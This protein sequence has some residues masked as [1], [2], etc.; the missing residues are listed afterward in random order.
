MLNKILCICVDGRNITIYNK[1][2]LDV[3]YKKTKNLQKITLEKPDK[4]NISQIY[5]R[6]KNIYPQKNL[7][8]LN[9]EYTVNVIT[10]KINIKKQK[11]TWDVPTGK[12]IQIIQLFAK[13]NPNFSP[14]TEGN[15]LQSL[16]DKTA[17][18][19]PGEKQILDDFIK[20]K[21][22][23]LI[24]PD[25]SFHK[26][27][28]ILDQVFYNCLS[29]GCQPMPLIDDKVSFMYTIFSWYI[30]NKYKHI[31]FDRVITFTEKTLINLFMLLRGYATKKNWFTEFLINI[32]RYDSI[33]P[34][35]FNQ[36]EANNFWFYRINK[37]FVTEYINIFVYMVVYINEYF[38]IDE[39]SP[40]FIFWDDDLLKKFWNKMNH[41]LS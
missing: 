5:N 14:Q 17:E 7:T 18:N 26:D 3:S 27:Y 2:E 20:Q 23:N 22:Y 15:I 21:H 13:L 35:L 19:Y 4:L 30:Y 8:K 29:R 38:A 12:Q 25:F 16:I 34:H 36:K 33:S 1:Q 9:I 32:E 41:F 6:I 28:Y 37:D 40:F 24:T 39:E 31:E 10:T 11:K